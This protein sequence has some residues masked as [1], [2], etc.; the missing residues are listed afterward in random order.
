MENVDPKTIRGFG[1]EWTRYDQSHLSHGELLELFDQY[2]SVFPMEVLTNEARGFD[3]GCGSG[4]WA[5]LV[6]PRV[7]RLTC[8]DP[9]PKALAVARTNLSSFTNCDFHLASAD[10]IP[11]PDD[12]QD[13]GYSLGVL[14]H[15]PNTMSAI[16]ACV[17]KLKP[18]APLLLY[19]YCD[20]ENRSPW[21]RAIW[22][23]S[24]LARRAIS[25][26]PRV[27]KLLLSIVVAVVVYL[28]LARLSKLLEH[29]GRP[30]ESIPL[31]YYRN[32]SFYTMKTD[33]LDRFGTRLEKRFS[34][35]EIEDMMVRAGL[36][37]I[38]FSDSPPYWC[39]VGSKR[40]A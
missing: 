33:A 18:G 27:P 14:H 10:N 38:Q 32:R 28:P 11:L 24:D 8:I 23:T 20:F 37:R 3:L 5:R 34:R 39:V 16:S 26:L 30:T 9:S 12:S 7:S 1:E 29:L 36:E 4:R 15:V 2:F 17:R 21:F 19:L 6:A 35:S 22:K 13:F 25:R 40:S 31:S